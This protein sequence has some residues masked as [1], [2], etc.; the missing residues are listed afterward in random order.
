MK[1]FLSLSDAVVLWCSDV[2]DADQRSESLPRRGPIRHNTFPPERPQAS[3]ASVL[4]RPSVSSPKYYYFIITFSRLRSAFIYCKDFKI[5]E[6][7]NQM[8]KLPTGPCE[9]YTFLVVNVYILM[10]L[11]NWEIYRIPSPRNH[12]HV[13]LL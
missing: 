3:T 6:K 9:S 1:T 11:C 12:E 4:S 2:G 10:T 7:K 13:F 8:P 5:V